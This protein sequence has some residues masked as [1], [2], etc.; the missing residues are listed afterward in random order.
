[1]IRRVHQHSGVLHL[2]GRAPS[3]VQHREAPLLRGAQVS[4]PQLPQREGVLGVL[5]PVVVLLLGQR[6]L[7]PVRGLQMLVVAL[8]LEVALDHI[9]Q[10][11][12]SA[13]QLR[14]RHDPN[15]MQHHVWPARGVVEP[16][17]LKPGVE[18]RPDT[19][20]GQVCGNVSEGHSAFEMV[21]HIAARRPAD[22]RQPHSC[23][24]GPQPGRLEIQR[25]NAP[26][27]LNRL[28]R[29]ADARRVRYQGVLTRN[30]VGHMILACHLVV[31][32]CRAVRSPRAA[33]KGPATRGLF[34]FKA[35]GERGDRSA[36]ARG[37]ACPRTFP[38]VHPRRNPGPRPWW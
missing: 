30:G 2:G 9:R 13:A 25:V 1:M 16:A 31:G 14:L 35:R 32:M 38:A 27:C 7:G 8:L 34:I 28:H 15:V 19:G 12:R 22:T 37:Q 4:V 29:R 26:V 3:V 23:V 6:L 24:L 20:P 11:Q 36:L 10:R 21:D 33:R 18:H 5:E 17:P